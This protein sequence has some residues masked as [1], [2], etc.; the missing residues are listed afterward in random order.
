MLKVDVRHNIDQV[1]GR[2]IGFDK[3]K[4][5]AMAKALTF[6]AQDTQK[7]MRNRLPRVFDRPTPFTLNSLRIESANVNKLSAA[8]FFKDISGREQHYL[9]PQVEGGFRPQKGLER[10]LRRIGPAGL[11]PGEY[12]V[13]AA[14]AELD[15][16][17]NVKRQQIVRILSQLKAFTEAGFSANATGSRRSRR[18][19]AR[20]QYFWS[21]GPGEF[22]G[23]RY[24]LPRGVWQRIS[25]GFGYAV[26]PVFI[27]VDRT[28][29]RLR[30]HFYR[31][32]TAFAAKRFEHHFRLQ[33]ARELGR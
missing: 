7:E 30:F 8:V 15:S 2:F 32:G 21:P 13:P 26:R 19:R 28:A 20:L 27:A 11:L 23:R 6:A 16:Y 5:V 25:T 18:S 22:N 24:H 29:Y 12:L 4:R 14:G 10:R 33:L 3:Q 1:L 17:G 31:D 9:V